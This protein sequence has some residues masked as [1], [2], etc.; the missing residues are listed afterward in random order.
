[1]ADAITAATPIATVVRNASVAVSR[2]Q[3]A[4]APVMSN[5]DSV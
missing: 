1:V 5:G 3:A 4:F 2:S